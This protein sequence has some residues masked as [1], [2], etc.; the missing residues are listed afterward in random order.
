VAFGSV[1]AKFFGFRFIII[2]CID[3]HFEFHIAIES[4][5]SPE[6]GVR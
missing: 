5:V 2:F 4:S 3:F 6:N 1:I